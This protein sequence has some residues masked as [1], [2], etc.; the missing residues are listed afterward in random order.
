MKA[1]RKH[2]SM[3]VKDAQNTQTNDNF[4]EDLSIY[5]V[6]NKSNDGFW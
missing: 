4:K 2:I 1:E 5:L 3:V 6:L